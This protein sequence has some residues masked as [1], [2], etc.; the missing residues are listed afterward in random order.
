MSTSPRTSFPQGAFTV[1]VPT[2]A[3]AEFDNSRSDVLLVSSDKV[4]FPSRR[5]QL[6]AAS[7]VLESLFDTADKGTGLASSTPSKGAA[8][9]GPDGQLA[10]RPH[11]GNVDHLELL[12]RHI[13][14]DL[15]R[16]LRLELDQIEM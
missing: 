11:V 9:K 14:R 2:P 5:C 10:Q 13:A 1:T 7:A 6:I 4:G 3:P 12:L 16:P 8:D 15:K